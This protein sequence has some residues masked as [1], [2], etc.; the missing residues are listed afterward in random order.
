MYVGH[1]CSLH[2][3]IHGD[4]SLIVTVH[5]VLRDGT[6]KKYWLLRNYS[7]LT[8][9]VINVETLYIKAIKSLKMLRRC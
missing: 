4:L 1:F 8:S 5:D 7:Q 3:F 9:N 6:V 2:H